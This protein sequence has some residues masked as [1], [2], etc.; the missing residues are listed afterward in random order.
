MLLSSSRNKKSKLD[1]KAH[2]GIFLGYSSSKG[3]IIFYLKSDKLILSR[4][5]KFDE[6]AGWD[7]KNQKTSYSD[8]FSIEQPQLSEDELVD[9]VPVRRTRSLKD[10]YQR[11]NLVSSEPTSYAEAQDSQAWRR[12]MQEELDMIEKNG[13]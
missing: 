5:V 6:A 1:Y 9:D 12:A 3:Y 2:Q 11:C 10:V 13:T 4:E 8:S 7:W